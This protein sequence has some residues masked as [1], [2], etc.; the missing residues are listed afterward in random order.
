[1]SLNKKQFSRRIFLA[2]TL[3]TTAGLTSAGALTSCANLPIIAD[4]NSKIRFGLVTYQWAKD[5]DLPTIIKNCE[6]AKVYGV[7]LRTTHKHGVE[8]NLNAQQR[9]EVKK[10]FA[11]SP[12]TVVGVGSDERYGTA[13]ADKLK[14]AIEATKDFIKLSCDVGGSGVKVK[15]GYFNKQVSHEKTIEQSGRTLN[16]LGRFATDYGQQIRVEVHDMGNDIPIMKAIM[17]VANHPNVAVCWN[18]NQQDLDGQGFEYNFNLVKNR[19][20]ATTHVRPLDSTDYPYQKLIN[21]LVEM[22]YNGWILLEASSEPEDKVK[23]LA[24]QAV[25]FKEMLKTAQSKT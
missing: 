7:E 4:K 18:S 1:M 5:W 22:N 21:N 10:R 8:R 15:P 11:D 19:L 6:T 14:K 20:G 9:K 25:L 12:V 2:R 16:I 17:D 23:A 13:D 3:Q 24:Q